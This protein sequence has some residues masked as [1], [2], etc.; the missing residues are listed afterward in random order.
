MLKLFSILLALTL[1]LTALTTP[2][3]TQSSSCSLSNPAFC[4]TFDQPS[5]TI[6][7][8][9]QLDPSRW[10]INHVNT[11]V[12]TDQ[13]DVNSWA[14]A[15]AMHCRDLMPNVMPPNDYFMC[16][17]EVGESMHFMEVLNDNSNYAYNDAMINQPF[18]F[19]N[20]TGRITFDVDA[21]TSGSH[22]WWIELWIIPEPIP[23]PHQ[24][25]GHIE[26]LTNGIGFFFIDPCGNTLPDQVGSGFVGMS[27]IELAQN[28]QAS[29]LLIPHSCTP[30][31]PD[32]LNHFEV[33]ISQNHL[34]LWGSDQNKENFK[35]LSVADNLNLPFTRGFIHFQDSHY[36]AKKAG[37]GVSPTVTYHWDNIG[38]DGPILPTP[39]HYAVP[40]ALDRRSNGTTNLGYVVN[41]TGLDRALVIHNVRLN[42]VTSATLTANVYAGNTD[43]RINNG[44]WHVIAGTGVGNWNAVAVNVALS[45]LR[46]G[47][48]TIDFRSSNS[49]RHVVAN[50]DLLTEGGTVA[51][52]TT[53]PATATSTVTPTTMP[54]TTSTVTPTLTPT[55]TP[56]VQPTN[57]STPTV[58]ALCEVNVKINGFEQWIV[59][60]IEFCQ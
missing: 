26:N 50:I 40:D 29:T 32:M 54:T 2:A 12:N 16:G 14:T 60:P 18:D 22:G 30:T 10:T 33:R 9:G 59:K 24:D 25:A 43:Y 55:I 35:Q 5:P 34:E 8:T 37:E 51:Q 58:I 17:P 4:D 11:G 42:D 45:E 3:L 38:F 19:A 21:K 49:L 46:V 53:V 13:G 27:R 52:P 31:E 41:S 44:P 6:S 36:D 15:D 1:S 39:I 20:R 57:T 56:T 47:D 23:G 48:N 7:R 28:A